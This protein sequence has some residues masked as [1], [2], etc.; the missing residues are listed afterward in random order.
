MVTKLS[1]SY[2][3]CPDPLSFESGI[4]FQDRVCTE[5]A[6]RGIILQNLGSKRYQLAIGENIQ[7]FEIKLDRRFMDTGRL[8]IEIAE[9]SDPQNPLWVPSGIYRNDNTWLYIQGCDSR[10]Y[11]FAKSLLVGLHKTGRYPTAES[12]GTVRKFYLPIEDAEKY[13]ALRVDIE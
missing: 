13:C 11:I 6:K 12:Y 4:E 10:L 8:S 1:P 9:K 5:L 2:P 3:G 7:G